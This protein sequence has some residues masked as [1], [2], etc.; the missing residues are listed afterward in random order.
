MVYIVSLLIVIL[1]SFLELSFLPYFSVL[2]ISIFIVLPFLVASSVKSRDYFVIIIALVAGIM[3]DYASSGFIGQYILIFVLTVL[4]GRIFFNQK[5]SYRSSKPFLIL[6]LISTL[7]IYL[8][9]IPI[10]INNNFVGWQN[11]LVYVIFGTSGTLI[12]GLI[13]YRLL[14]PYFSWIEKN[15]E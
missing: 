10:L 7:T 8:T 14:E 3:F 2:N 12:F 5:S 9:Q 6:L 4:V 11:Y 13:L 15:S 1:L